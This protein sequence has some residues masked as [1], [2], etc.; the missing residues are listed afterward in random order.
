MQIPQKNTLRKRIAERAFISNVTY[1]FYNFSMTVTFSQRLMVL[2]YV[3][4][5]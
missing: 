2:L 3:A 4:V 5:E 1:A